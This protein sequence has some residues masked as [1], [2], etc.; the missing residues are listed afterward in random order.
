MEWINKL[1]MFLIAVYWTGDRVRANPHIEQL[2]VA[3]ES[4]FK[5]LISSLKELKIVNALNF[6]SKL[7]GITTLLAFVGL[8]FAAKVDLSSGTRE[9]IVLILGMAFLMFGSIKWVLGGHKEF[10]SSNKLLIFIFL[11]WPFW[12]AWLEVSEGMPVF[13]QMFIPFNR[14]WVL[15]G[16]SDFSVY[17]IWVKAG[18]LS[19]LSLGMILFYYCITWGF[20]LFLTL[21]SICLVLFPVYLAKIIDNIWPSDTFFFFTILVF[22]V[23]TIFS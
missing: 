23:L 5:E 4:G 17:G 3:M 11:S 12:L 10:I 15:S 6:L 14:F 9:L 18:I 21:I 8:F 20:S 13:E 19:V 2:I 22:F 16:F 7:Y 1:L